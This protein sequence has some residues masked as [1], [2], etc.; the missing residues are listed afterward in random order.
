MSALLGK[1][2]P[3]STGR[4]GGGLLAAAR[5][6]PAEYEDWRQGVN[7]NSHLTSV[8]APLYCVDP[9]D[10]TDKTIE[11]VGEVLEF[12]PFLIYSAR[13]CSTFMDTQEL[14]DLA[15][16]GLA[17][18]ESAM[19]SRQLTSDDATS[20]NPGLADSADVVGPATAGVVQAFSLLIE[21]AQSCGTIGE[22]VFHVPLRALP[23]LVAENL[24]EYT[25]GLW[26]FGPFTVVA[27][28]YNEAVL[29]DGEAALTG[30]G[31]DAYFYVTGPVEVAV[32]PVV[33]ANYSQVS[34][35]ESLALVERLA[36]LRFDPN[37][38]KA[39]R[40]DF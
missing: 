39:I 23:Y 25:G 30:D 14:I 29:P 36:I 22:L 4:L 2:P 9:A 24:V 17:N 3:I 11:P 34:L 16:R 10:A 33:D 18:T 19:I 37:C 15:R 7:F 28:D 21:A 6:L 27:D 26:K 40:V 38:V 31:S 13:S 20:T 5:P 8:T 32:G 12:L 35:N 1:L